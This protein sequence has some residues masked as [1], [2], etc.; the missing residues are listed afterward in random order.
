MTYPVNNK[1]QENKK[2]RNR[3][4]SKFSKKFFFNYYIKG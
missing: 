2:M 1:R 3:N 4:K